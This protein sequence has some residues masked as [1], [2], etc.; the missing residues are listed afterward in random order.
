MLLWGLT[1]PLIKISLEEIGPITLGF[2][3][4]LFGA[5]P[6]FIYILVKMGTKKIFQ[7][8][9][10]SYVLFL[11]VGLT[12]FYLP[13]AAQNTG[14]SMMEPEIAASL[15][16]ILQATFPVFAI[17][18]SVMFLKEVIGKKKAIGTAI[19]LTGTILLVTQGGVDITSTAL[20]GNLL[21][22]SSA[23]CY[24]IASVITKKSLAKYEPLTLITMAMVFSSFLFFPT[25]IAVEP[26]SQIADISM[27]TWLSI[28]YLGL[29]GNGFALLL[30]YIVLVKTQLSKQVLFTY[31][32]PLFG[33]VF[34]H[35]ILGETISLLTFFFGMLIVIGVAIVQYERKT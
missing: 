27:I 33:N 17:F 35:I 23:V 13:L 10:K 9:R 16:S 22:L 25:S 31:L 30:W 26:V 18:L 24:A 34:S 2:L 20:L 12:Q 4:S 5:I 3:R 15:S 19:A 14:M 8:T 21:L 1:F 28:I 7:V 29:I 6:L 32:I 11:L